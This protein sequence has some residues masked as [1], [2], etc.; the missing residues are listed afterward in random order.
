MFHSINEFTQ[1][2]LIMKFGGCLK[3][4]YLKI[5]SK[6]VGETAYILHGCKQLNVSANHVFIIGRCT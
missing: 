3:V 6:L 2:T 4:Q 1:A 5:Q